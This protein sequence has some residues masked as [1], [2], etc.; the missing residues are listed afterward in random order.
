[1]KSRSYYLT[2]IFATFFMGSSFIVSKLLLRDLAPF[3]LVGWRFVIAA[4]STVPLVL[5]VGRSAQ[6]KDE[7]RPNWGVVAV[8]GLVQ[9]TGVMGLLFLSMQTISAANAA[10]LLFT[11][12]IWVAAVGHFLPGERLSRWQVISL[13]AGLVGVILA[14]GLREANS[15]L[16]G[17]LLGLGAALCWSA[18]T[19]LSKFT[20]SGMH[21][22]RL[23]MWQMG[24]GGLLLLGLSVINGEAH[25][26]PQ[27]TTQWSWFL[28][29]A[30]PSSVGSFGLW[31]LALQ[32]GGAAR[33]SSFLFLAPLFATGLSVLTL[34]TTLTGWQWLGGV[35][36]GLSIYGMNRRTNTR[37]I[38]S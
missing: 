10:I 30:V 23:N 3:W 22:L 31:F 12:P 6:K 27:N 15:D 16:R 13:L 14:M 38:V 1:M 25:G 9:T 5:W 21:P 28:W 8:I 37:S 18:G 34:G 26:L 33:S 20:K 19:L 4:I 29:L 11:N 7:N 17:N 32:R 2:L 24:L 36:V 35:L